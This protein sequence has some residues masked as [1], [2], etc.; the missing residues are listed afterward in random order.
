MNLGVET[1]SSTSSQLQKFRPLSIM[2][3]SILDP[4]SYNLFWDAWKNLT[5]NN[6][7]FMIT[8]RYTYLSI[9]CKIEIKLNKYRRRG[10]CMVKLCDMFNHTRFFS[11]TAFSHYIH[12]S[13][14]P[15][16]FRPSTL[17]PTS[18]LILLYQTS[19][20]L[21]SSFIIHL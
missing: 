15:C 4:K 18:S 7:F 3:E 17:H 21:C 8:I 20:C 16:L 5:K 12:H 2:G 11:L 9:C 19:I 13:H 1:T 14:I 6:F 10:R